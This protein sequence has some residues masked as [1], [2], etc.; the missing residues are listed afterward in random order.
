M[1][2]GQ[3][4]TKIAPPSEFARRRRPLGR[5]AIALAA[6]AVL[7]LVALWAIGWWT[8][9][10]FT[11]ETN[12]AYLAADAVVI[13]PKISGYVTEVLVG[14]NERVAAG[15]TL[16][17]IDGASY[18]AAEDMAEA[19]MAQR[20]ADLV[21]YRADAAKQEAARAEAAA[22]VTVAD[23]AARFAA[24]DAARFQ[25]LA[26]AGAD[27]TQRR[28]QAQ[29][30][31]DQ[32]EGQAVAARAAVQTASRELDSLKAQIGQGEAALKVAEAKVKSAQS[33]LAGI[34]VTTPIAG[35]VGDRTVRAGQYVQPGTRLMTIVPV[36]DMY[37]VANFKET[38]VG[39]M[40]PGQ[41]VSIT[42]DALPDAKI[43]GEVDSLAPGTGAEFAPTR[44]RWRCCA[45]ACR[46]RWL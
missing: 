7:A 32:T 14:D 35:L 18:Q 30:T 40:R 20:Q 11:E 6:A 45:P 28:D 21:R 13:A 16:L 8:A 4:N 10:R 44:R 29:S 3:Q 25:R 42:I 43:R 1:P 23:A 15:A 12:N 33:D 46:P 2:D 31:R 36:Q 39:R 5:I 37:L 38:Q 17:R 26:K 22:Q 19:E 34:V 27:T 9:G 24:E 41:P